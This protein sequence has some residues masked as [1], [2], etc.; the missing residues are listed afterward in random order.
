MVGYYNYTVWMTYLSLLIGGLGVFLTLT[1]NPL[2]GVICLG[3]SGCLDLFDGKIARLKKDRTIEE[4][5]YGIQIDSLTDLICF[6]VLPVAIGYAVGM[7]EMYFIPLF[8]FYILAGMIRLAYFNVREMNSDIDEKSVFYGVPITTAAMII[9]FIWL[10]R[11]FLKEKFF[12]LYAIILGLLMFLFL[13]KIKI[14]KPTVKI[15]IIFSTILIIIF[16]TLLILELTL[17]KG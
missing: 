9:P 15:S 11:C 5:Q 14:K 16:I 1:G 17:C 10:L 8:C 4:K 3:V 12:I 7:K 2:G 6:G 13:F